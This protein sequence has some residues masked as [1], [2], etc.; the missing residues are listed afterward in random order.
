MDIWQ[1]F[2]RHAHRDLEDRSLDNGLS[3]KGKKQCERLIGFLEDQRP[4]RKPTQVFSSPKRRCAE[5]AEYV[6]AWAGVKVEIEFSLD[7]QRPK[8]GDRDFLNRIRDWHASQK[9][10]RGRCYVSHGDVLPIICRIN[11]SLLADIKKGDLFFLEKQSV[12]KINGVREANK[13]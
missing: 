6:A 4:L 13:E 1:L 7:E 11:G 2:I 8:E 12:K 3:D 10:L 5:T 9:D